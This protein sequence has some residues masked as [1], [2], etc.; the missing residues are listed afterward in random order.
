MIPI[1]WRNHEKT[2][3]A[4]PVLSDAAARE[5]LR[6]GALPDTGV[7]YIEVPP[8]KIIRKRGVW[9]TLSYRAHTEATAFLI[10]A[11]VYEMNVDVLEAIR[12]QIYCYYSEVAGIH[13]LGRMN[14]AA[15][16][17]GAPKALLPLIAG[18]HAAIPLTDLV[19][20]GRVIA[21]T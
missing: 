4:C 10:S 6:T 3:S 7:H 16:K 12:S 19:Y 11:D 13:Y 15:E 8:T 2:Y 20:T 21:A 5:Y 17:E 14:Y 18:L 9:L 1:V